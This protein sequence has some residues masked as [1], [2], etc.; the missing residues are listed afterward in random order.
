MK[1]IFI[2]LLAVLCSQAC[3]AQA[4]EDSCSLVLPKFTAS[5]E[6]ITA[7]GMLAPEEL[8]RIKRVLTEEAGLVV[9]RFTYII[10]CGEECDAQEKTVYGD[11]FSE[12]DQKALQA[13]K[14]RNVLSMQCILGRDKEGKLVAFKPF[15]YYIR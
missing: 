10:D 2:I 4:N 5:F 1:S 11:T 13:M 9:V 12:E 15:L 8:A 7:K 14:S 3:F 6:G